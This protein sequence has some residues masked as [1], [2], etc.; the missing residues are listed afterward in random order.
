MAKRIK[1]KKEIIA[2][3]KE[4]DDEPLSAEAIIS[5][6]G[7]RGVKANYL[8]KSTNALGQLMKAIKGVSKKKANLKSSIGNNYV[9]AVYYL[10]DEEAF[11]EWLEKVS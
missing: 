2:I 9:S 6:L 3:L 11:N 8:P 4:H 7:E 1:L 10:D 5:R